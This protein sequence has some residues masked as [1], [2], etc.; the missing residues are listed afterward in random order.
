MRLKWF[1]LVC[2]FSVICGSSCSFAAASYTVTD[3]GS[4]NGASTG[5]AINASG[6]VA[7]E[8]ENGSKA[9]LYSS[10]ALTDVT[11]SDAQSVFVEGMNDSGE[12]VGMA[13]T[14]SNTSYAFLYNHG[15]TTNLSVAM[16]VGSQLFNIAGIDNAG[17]VFGTTSAGGFVYTGGVIHYFTPANQGAYA[18]NS[19]GQVIGYSNHSDTQSFLY[20]A[21]SLQAVSFP[22]PSPSPSDYTEAD[23]INNEGQVFGFA[24]VQ[25]AGINNHLFMYSDGVMTD[26]GAPPPYITNALIMPK[27]V[28][29]SGQ[30]VGY[31]SSSGGAVHAFFYEN[32]T[33]SSLES[34]VAPDAGWVFVHAAGINDLGQITGV[35]FN[36]AGQQDAFLLTP[37]VSPEPASL[38]VL[39]IT[40]CIVLLRRNCCTKR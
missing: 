16:G 25:S 39:G 29:N 2:G 33:Y 9:F 14:A 10:G 30:M 5:L 37:I 6:Q 15:V 20:S 4:L 22:D 24:S 12:V 26:L 34:L 11:P 7:G 31:Y 19:S 3:L 28:N 23:V 1:S 18:V 21:G 40:A 8:Y 36:P 32:G 13:Y 38:S 27:G 35:G 17:D